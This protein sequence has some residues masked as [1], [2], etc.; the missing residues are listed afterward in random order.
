[1]DH[2]A[3]VSI[4]KEVSPPRLVK[5]VSSMEAPISAVEILLKKI[6]H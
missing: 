3:S 4:E 2:P 5:K 6:E 1:L